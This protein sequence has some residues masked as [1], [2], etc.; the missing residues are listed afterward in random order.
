QLTRAGFGRTV[1][2]GG[3]GVPTCTSIC[4]DCR[5]KGRYSTQVPRSRNCARRVKVV[6]MG[7]NAHSARDSARQ[8]GRNWQRSYERKEHPCACGSNAQPPRP[9]PHCRVPLSPRNAESL[10]CILHNRHGRRQGNRGC[11]AACRNGAQNLGTSHAIESLAAGIVECTD[12][13]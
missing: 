6:W 11:G 2:C 5:K 7:K 12:I 13:F 1:P 9:N 4:S 3:Q 8:E 10:V